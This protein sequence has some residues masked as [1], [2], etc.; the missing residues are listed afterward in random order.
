M[1]WT[2]EIAAVNAITR[3]AVRDLIDRGLAN[4]IPGDDIAKSLVALD[5]F[6]EV[7]F[8]KAEPID[9]EAEMSDMVAGMKAVIRSLAEPVV[10]NVAP[11]EVYVAAPIVN[12]PPV[13]VYVSAPNVT[14]EGKAELPIIIPAPVVNVTTPSE[15]AI[16]SLPERI[17]RRQIR[18]DKQQKITET[19]DVE[20]DA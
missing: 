12:M 13:E 7:E 17:T 3:S 2:D 5:V 16:T 1:T 4:D 18:R 19:V 10:V 15:L 14:F 11:P 9:A 6:G 20:E 8:G